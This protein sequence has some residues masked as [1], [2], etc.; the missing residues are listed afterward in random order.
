[1]SASP[2]KFEDADY[3]LDAARRVFV[4]GSVSIYGRSDRV[5]DKANDLWRKGYVHYAA[6]A[7]KIEPL[8]DY[9]RRSPSP[10]PSDP[11]RAN[12]ITDN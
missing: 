3:L 8:R 4:M 11:R 5:V 10:L 2:T 6:K 1:M 9:R 7:L 12:E